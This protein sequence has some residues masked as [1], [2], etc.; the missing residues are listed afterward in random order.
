[1]AH[2]DQQAL[3]DLEIREAQKGRIPLGPRQN[4]RRE[5]VTFKVLPLRME[6]AVVDKM[7][8]AW[9][10]R[11]IRSRMEF[12]Q[13]RSASTSS[14]SGPRTRRRFLPTTLL[15]PPRARQAWRLQRRSL[16]GQPTTPEVRVMLWLLCLL[17]VC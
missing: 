7:D 3:H 6:S 14:N 13:E 17:E 1:M 4:A 12:F 8:E 15:C 2:Q 5:G 9:R 16:G 10:S 11:G